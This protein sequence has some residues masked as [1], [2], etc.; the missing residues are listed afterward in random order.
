MMLKSKLALVLG[1]TLPLVAV[2]AFFSPRGQALAERFAENRRCC[3]LPL[4]RAFS[5]ALQEAQGNP[6]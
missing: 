1:V 3:Q 2:A 4:A 5:I 6:P